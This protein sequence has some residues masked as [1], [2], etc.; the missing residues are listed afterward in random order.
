MGGLFDE[1]MKYYLMK[2]MELGKCFIQQGNDEGFIQPK[3]FEGTAVK[4]SHQIYLLE[5]EIRGLRSG[6]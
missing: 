3:A 6:I 4:F 1:S 5:S 2:V